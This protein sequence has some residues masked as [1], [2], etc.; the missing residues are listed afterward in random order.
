[1][2]S[3]GDVVVYGSSGVMRVV[4][5]SEESFAGQTHRY[6]VLC[7]GASNLNSK[8][9]VPLDNEKLVAQMRPLVTK[10]EILDILHNMDRYPEPE[11]IPDTRARQEMFKSIIESGD[12]G[13]IIAMIRSIQRTGL[14]RNAEGKK[15]YLSD[16][17]LMNKAQ[18]ILYTELS[19][20]LG[21]SEDEVVDFIERECGAI[22]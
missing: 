12:R 19:I 17:N 4:D 21:I 18:R 15:N 16:E 1:M 10:E 8:T 2:H 3:I 20:V 6:Y 14:R 22:A 13:R 5:I 11:W 7:G 9:F